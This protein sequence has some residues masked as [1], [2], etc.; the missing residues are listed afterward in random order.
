MDRQDSTSTTPA[1]ASTTPHRGLL[2][3]TFFVSLILKGLDGA[4]ELLGGVVLLLVTPSQIQRAV[5]AVT[6]GE[7]AQD[8]NDLV[9]NL[10]VRYASQLNVSLTHFGAW[11]LLVHGVV[12]VLLVGA[13]LRNR[14]WAY[15]WLIGF[16]VAFIGY[17]GYELV[18]HYTLGLL[19]L[20]LFDVFIVYLTVREYRRRK[21][22]GR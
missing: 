15:P 19:L 22:H 6:R 21:A 16:L 10:L 11:Y 13:V 3:R 9:A 8:P 14:L 18:V 5:A 1:T 2:D 20:T 12:K 7:L 17:Q 4:V